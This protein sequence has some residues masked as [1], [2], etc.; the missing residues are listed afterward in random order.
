MFPFLSSDYQFVINVRLILSFSSLVSSDYITQSFINSSS[1]SSL[2]LSDRIPVENE[3]S[4]IR[5]QKDDK[6]FFLEKKR[7]EWHEMI[8]MV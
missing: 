4:C 7:E 3:T 1:V 2:S 8:M 5:W 6:K